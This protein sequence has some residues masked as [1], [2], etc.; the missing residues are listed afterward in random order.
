MKIVVTGGAGFIG[1]HVVDAYLAAGHTV[2]VVD[3]LSTGRKENL[4]PNARFVHMDIRSPELIDLLRAE[5]PQVVNHHAANPSVKVST[6]RPAFDAE[7]NILGLINVL[8][9]SAQA[10]VEKVIYI[11]SGGAMYGDPVYLPMDEAHPIRPRSPYAIT[12][13]VGEHY[14][15][16]FAQ[17]AGMRYTHLRYAN[18]YGP[19]QDPYGEAGVV[20]IFAA[21]LLNGEP[22]TIDWDGEQQRDFV[23]VGDCARANVLALDGGDGQAYNVGT[24]RGTSVNELYATL[25]R[26][27]G[28][29]REPLRGP[30]RPGDVRVS[31]LDCSKIRR[32]LGWQAETDLATGLTMT[33][34]HLQHIALRSRHPIDWTQTNTD[35]RG[36]SYFSA[37]VHGHPRPINPAEP[38]D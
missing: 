34:T 3:N 16:Y 15:T 12:K 6:E 19:R 22:C 2:V 5:R 9:A 11:S 18:V 35:E 27:V 30:K 29:K 17:A 37:F 20:A 21:R 26:A 14:V 4:A 32:E 31:V 33:I 13:G 1:S 7:I 10:G 28:V 36:Q 38:E 8:S 25:A 23:F 24:G